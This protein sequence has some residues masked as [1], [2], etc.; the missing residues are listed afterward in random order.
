MTHLLLDWLIA[1]DM[2]STHAFGNPALKWILAGY[3]LGQGS[4]IAALGVRLKVLGGARAVLSLVF[5]LHF[6]C[7][8]VV[9]WFG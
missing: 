4:L 9:V 7:A 2:A 8:A 6:I 3:I 5:L 1:S